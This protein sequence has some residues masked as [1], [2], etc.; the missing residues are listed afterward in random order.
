MA[1]FDFNSFISTTIK[2]YS[3]YVSPVGLVVESLKSSFFFYTIHPPLET[4]DMADH[5][6]I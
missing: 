4:W 2:K 6:I 3:A 5:G 1:Q